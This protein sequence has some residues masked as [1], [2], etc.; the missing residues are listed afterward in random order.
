MSTLN[1]MTLLHQSLTHSR[2]RYGDKTALIEAGQNHSYQA[3]DDASTHLAYSLHHL[4]VR[5][6]DRVVVCLG[7]RVETVIAF[8][9]ILKAG[10][11][12]SNVGAETTPEQLRYIV[13]D[14]AADVVI[15]DAKQQQAL[16]EQPPQW[17]VLVDEGV[18]STGV[19]LYQK[20]LVSGA[21][22][23]PILPT[24]L[25]VDLASIIYTSGST[26]QPKGVMLTHRNM[27]AALFSLNAYLGYQDTD[28]TLCSLPLSFDYGLYQLLMTISVGGTL[29][30]EPAFLWPILLIKTFKAHP[31]TIVPLV[32]TMLTLLH[33]YASRHNLGFPQVRLISNTGAALRPNHISK[34][35]ALFP[36]AQ[37]F[38]MYGLTE[39]KRCTYLP[40]QDLAAKPNSIGI[41]I[42]N[43]ELWL[44]DE[45]GDRIA[46]PGQIG[47]LVIR[48]ATVM[49]GYWR[50]PEA[51]AQKLKDGP[52]PHEKV[53]HT[54]DLCY[55]D[56]EGYLYFEGRLD[57]VIK[58]RGLKVS[59][60][61]VEQHLYALA[62]V[63]SAM[64][65][66]VVEADEEAFLHAFVQTEQDVKL[67][68]E[69]I[70][71]HCQAHLPPYKVPK[72]IKLLDSL[73][74]TSN[75]KID[76]L[77][78]RSMVH[79]EGTTATLGVEL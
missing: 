17:L 24:V 29:L 1:H 12:V 65:L 36:Q 48:G 22:S 34:M 53:L 42:P 28:T 56:K 73:P 47:Q 43:T 52:L 16:A 11:V 25:D 8:Y 38:S 23:R 66:G 58:S 31:V 10:A 13:T 57:Q 32:P 33:D 50:K 9:A 63:K 76:G 51:T 7:N 19:V 2:R 44:I 74:R 46:E 37:V 21:L 64:V 15:T 78:L 6:G 5:R 26:G 27:L 41:A 59:P 71:Q 67:T 60:V 54:G 40:P 4:G 70:L 75:G 14:L 69:A 35:K 3:L 30:L 49:A 39:C 77:A 20:L 61:E 62:G 55:I 18:E 79:L 72:S 45:A 68:T